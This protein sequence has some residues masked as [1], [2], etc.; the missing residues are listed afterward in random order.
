MARIWNTTAEVD[1]A[2]EAVCKC[3]NKIGTIPDPLAQTYRENIQTIR[4]TRRGLVAHFYE[5]LA[6]RCPEALKWF[7]DG[8]GEESPGK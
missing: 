1:A 6:V 7:A 2:V 5:E 3:L 8:T 4:R